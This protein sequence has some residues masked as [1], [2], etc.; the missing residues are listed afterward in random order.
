MVRAIERGLRPGRRRPRRLAQCLAEPV[1]VNA[2]H[3]RSAYL[4]VGLVEFRV[5]VLDVGQHVDDGPHLKP[6]DM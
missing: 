1:P 6:H 2:V 4:R 5:L 3:V